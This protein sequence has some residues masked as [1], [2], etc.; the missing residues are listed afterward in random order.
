MFRVGRAAAD[1][2][3]NVLAA[4]D[5]V[6][7]GEAAAQLEDAEGLGGDTVLVGREVDHAVRDDG[8]NRVVRQEDVFDVPLQKL[9]V[10]RPEFC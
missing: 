7:D 4:D 10:R 6:R 2:V 9:D 1:D 8:V 5:D 3:R